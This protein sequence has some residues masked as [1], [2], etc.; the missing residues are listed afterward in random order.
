MNKPFLYPLLLISLIH[1]PLNCL[2]GIAELL[3]DL[4]LHYFKYGNPLLAHQYGDLA[5]QEK[6]STVYIHYGCEYAKKGDIEK[7]KES[8]RKLPP[9]HVEEV[10]LASA[11][12]DDDIERAIVY[13]K[14]QN[15]SHKTIGTLAHLCYVLGKHSYAEQCYAHLLELSHKKN[16]CIREETKGDILY[17]FRNAARFYKKCGKLN[18]A[19]LH[20]RILVS[21]EDTGWRDLLFAAKIFYKQNEL[22][23]AKTILVASNFNDEPSAHRYLALIYATRGEYDTCK[24]HLEQVYTQFPHN[25]EPHSLELFMKEQK[26]LSQ[27]ANLL[28]ELAIAYQNAQNLTQASRYLEQ[29]E[30][31]SKEIFLKEWCTYC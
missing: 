2:S 25:L 26:K 7:A 28:G 22:E 18:L 15:E 17:L 27:E 13:A 6:N 20:C 1:T 8:F 23:S 9:E 5:L 31:L 10:F 3:G 30:Q 16:L 19:Q 29:A 4:S 21:I 11:I 12:L 14:N 24:Y